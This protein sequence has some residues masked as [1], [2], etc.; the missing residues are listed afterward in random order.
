MDETYT[1]PQKTDE[2]EDNFST[3]NEWQAKAAAEKARQ[4]IG[5]PTQAEDPKGWSFGR[6]LGAT[7][8]LAGA[9]GLGAGGA[10]VAADSLIP[11]K[12][13]ASASSTVLNGEGLQQSVDR[14]IEQIELKKIYPSGPT[15]RLDVISEANKIYSDQNGIVQPGQNVTVVAKE[16]PIF[17]NITYEAVPNSDS[18]IPSPKTR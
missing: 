12:E 3:I 18:P 10:T 7:I 13:V 17:G 9:V 1:P 15:E 2:I 11:G 4:L 6:K 5:T 14:A 8:A 16:S